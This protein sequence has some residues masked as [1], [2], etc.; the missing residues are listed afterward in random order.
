MKIHKYLK[1]VR[2]EKIKV[3]LMSISY[4][5]LMV[6]IGLMSTL[7]L[8]ES[9]FYFSP[10]Y[11]KTILLILLLALLITLIW[12]GIS[13]IIINQNRHQNYSWRKLASIIG[14]NIFPKNEDTALNAYQ[15]ETKINT[16]QSSELADNF[17]NNISKKI[18]EVE[19]WAT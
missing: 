5:I 9:V 14:K 16:N 11:K 8:L 18:N 1:L 13:Y 4:I 17:I 7:L 15:I 10:F 2:S 12:I 6:Y 19:L 3:D